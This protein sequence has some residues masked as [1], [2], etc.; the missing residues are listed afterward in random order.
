MELLKVTLPSLRDIHAAWSSV[1]AYWALVGHC[2]FCATLAPEFKDRF[3]VHYWIT[4]L[5]G[6]GGG[7]ASAL[8]IM[9]PAKASISL[10]SSN[11]LGFTW[12]LCWWLMTYFP[13]NIPNKLHSFWPV[14]MITKA[15]VA[16]CRANLIVNR[17]DLC[18]VLYPD[19]VMASIL[20]GTIAA[21]GGKYTTDAIRQVN[22]A[23]SAPHEAS[24]PTYSWR[25]A[26]LG[27]AFYFL[28]AKYSVTQFLA[29]EEATAVLLTVFVGQSLLSDLTGQP[30]DWTKPIINTVLTLANIPAGSAAIKPVKQAPEVVKPPK[31]SATGKP[32]Q[33][34]QPAAAAPKNAAQ[35]GV[36]GAAKVQEAE[37]TEASRGS[38]A[39][40]VQPAA[41]KGKK[42]ADVNLQSN[43]KNGKE[44]AKDGKEPRQNS[45]RETKKR[46]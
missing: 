5:G 4:F 32:Q 10:L 9:N 6:F 16:F 46:K 19:V 43:G 33:V 1:P 20:L 36:A 38:S 34:Q 8:V 39:A 26:F 12:T 11:T 23:A 21:C 37:G 13:Y 3:I 41:P 35:N 44:A 45:V 28:A 17:V 2:L 22:N 24:A 14:K 15:C 7:I 30:C 31:P 40:G 42:T 18:M 29:P 25:S 27:S